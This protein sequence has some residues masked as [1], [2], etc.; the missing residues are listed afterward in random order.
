MNRYEQTCNQIEAPFVRV[1]KSMRIHWG[2]SVVYVISLLL[3]SC[4]EPDNFCTEN[5]TGSGCNQ[6]T[7][8]KTCPQTAEPEAEHLGSDCE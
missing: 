4:G 5:P 7:E 3:V 2:W 6:P 1:L 8:I